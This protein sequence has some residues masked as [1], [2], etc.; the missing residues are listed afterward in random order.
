MQLK[1]KKLL[2]SKGL[3]VVA[4]ALLFGALLVPSTKVLAIEQAELGEACKFAT[5]LPAEQCAKG[6]TC[7]QGDDDKFVCVD[8]D[9]GIADVGDNIQ[10]GDTSLDTAVVGI[11]NLAL[12]FLGMIAVIVIL[13]GGFKWMT[14]GGNDEKVGEARKWIFSGII[15]LAIVL[16]AW[17]ISKFVIQQLA[18]ATGSGTFAE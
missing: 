9:F 8:S 1:I 11:I 13:I 12:S 7:K 3:L 4:V 6:L 17:A 5:T 15:G 18:Q 10:L 16:S 2:K 14:A